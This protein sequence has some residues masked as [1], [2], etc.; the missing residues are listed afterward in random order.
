M[1]KRILL[2][3]GYVLSMR[4]DHIVKADVIIE[5]KYIV[6]V[7][8]NVAKDD[9]FDEII[10]VDN[11]LLMPSF[12]NGHTHSAMVFARSIGDNLSLEDWLFNLIIPMENKLTYDDVYTLSKVAFLEY[13]RSGITY[14]H[15]SYYFSDA[16]IKAAQEMHL[17]IN[18]I[19]QPGNET[20]M[21]EN[22]YLAYQNKYP[23][24]LL[25][26][27]I[28]AL[29]TTSEEELFL[30]KNL[31][32]KYRQPFYL[33]LGETLT[34]INNFKKDHQESEL[35]YLVNLGLFKY[36][37]AIFH[38]VYLSDDDLA[39]CQKHHISIIS[40]MASNLKLHSGIAP[41][42]K[43]L[44]QGINVGLGSDGA[45]S[46]NS[47][48][49]FKELYLASTIPFLNEKE[50]LPSAFELLKMANVNVMKAINNQDALY[51][52]PKQRADI[53]MIDLKHPSMQV[54]NNLIAN[55]VYAGS[56]SLIKMTMSGGKILYYDHHYF[57]DQQT[58]DQLYL[59]AEKIAQRLKG[60]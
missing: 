55:L 29:Y 45:S 36:G 48:N 27:G 37:G 41:L 7:G 12:K 4:D 42:N 52:E 1:K 53:I 23:D 20:K 38:G 26:F 18:Y 39:L 50:Y 47:L 51:L 60:N 40:N 10:D 24:A 17:R 49:M 6:F 16:I 21:I 2:K 58:I 28:H 34:E 44:H 14:F 56:T 8:D 22:N 3:N 30:M 46:N 5:D 19:F 25:S 32:E 59:K 54:K 11:N 43:Y 13:I 9:Y 31:V 35:A 57:L 33:H 15:E